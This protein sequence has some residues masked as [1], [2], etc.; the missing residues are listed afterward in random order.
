M[1]LAAIGVGLPPL[2]WHDCGLVLFLECNAKRECTLVPLDCSRASPH[3]LRQVMVNLF[4]CILGG[5]MYDMT[6]YL[7]LNV[8]V[9]HTT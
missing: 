1:H 5:T 7:L 8:I 6:R 2:D 3:C 9:I 4:P